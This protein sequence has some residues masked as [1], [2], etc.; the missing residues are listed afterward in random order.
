MADSQF[1]SRCSLSSEEVKEFY[2]QGGP[3]AHESTDIVFLSIEVRRGD[4]IQL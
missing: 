3:E 4:H 2:W 1:L